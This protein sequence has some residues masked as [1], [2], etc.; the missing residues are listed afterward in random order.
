MLY[1]QRGAVEREFANLKHNWA[2]G[3]L[4]VRRIGRVRL[5]ADLTILARLA[6]A[7]AAGAPSRWPRRP[8]RQRPAGRGHLAMP[9]GQNQA[10]QHR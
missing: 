3:R 4:R 6:C 9:V 5:R 7:L 2:L 1:R 8:G 10:R